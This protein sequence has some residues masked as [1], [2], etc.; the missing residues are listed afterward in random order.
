MPG[1]LVLDVTVTPHRTPDNG[2]LRRTR[3]TSEP[4][5]AV[6]VDVHEWPEDAHVA[7]NIP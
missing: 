4:R 2:P 7:V 6:G 5:G 3:G 1:S